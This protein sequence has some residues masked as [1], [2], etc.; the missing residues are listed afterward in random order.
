MSRMAGTLGSLSAGGRVVMD[1]LRVSHV[2]ELVLMPE[3]GHC[4][5]R[6]PPSKVQHMRHTEGQGDD[7]VVS[8]TTGPRSQNPCG[9]SGMVAQAYSPSAGAL[10]MVSLPNLLGELRAHERPRLT[11]KVEGI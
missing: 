3:M 5:P 9:K 4:N 8:T 6:S 2:C 7:S 11:G 1:V 10:E